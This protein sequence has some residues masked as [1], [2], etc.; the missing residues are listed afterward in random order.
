MSGDRPRRPQSAKDMAEAAFKQVTVKAPA[1]L[2]P[3]API[4][5]GAREMVSL[6]LDKDVLEHF[7]KDGPGWQERINTAL[8]TFVS[9]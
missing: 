7:Q 2:P 9:G 1:P 3:R 5:P 4:L 6:R 8:K